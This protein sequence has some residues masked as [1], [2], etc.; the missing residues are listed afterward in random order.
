MII[1]GTANSGK[2]SGG[3]NRAVP[4][5]GTSTITGQLFGIRKQQLADPTPTFASTFMRAGARRSAD[6]L[7]PCSIL[8]LL[9]AS[10]FWASPASAQSQAPML[11]VE[12]DAFSGQPNPRWDLTSVQAE[13]FRARLRELR[14]LQDGQ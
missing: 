7:P 8:V 1:I 3:T 6:R 14:P 12:L 10:L 4:Q 11:E 13:E 2:V 5:P 9:C